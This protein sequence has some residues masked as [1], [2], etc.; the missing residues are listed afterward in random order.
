MGEMKVTKLQDA[1]IGVTR[2]SMDTDAIIYFVQ[3]DAT[4][5]ILLS[6][7][8]SRISRSQLAG[9]TSAIT[10]TE[11]LVRPIRSKDT[12]QQQKIKDLL[13]NSQNMIS[14]S[15]DAAIAEIAADLRARYNMRT[16]DALH[17]ATAIN[18][19]CDAFLTNNAGDF[20]RITEM[21]VLVLSELEL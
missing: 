2:L 13:L 18:F 8:F 7:I 9:V 11:A 12:V 15:V 5:G 14:V 16:P 20:R 4:H 17:A 6:E 1:L 10:L 19:G 3:A 21:N